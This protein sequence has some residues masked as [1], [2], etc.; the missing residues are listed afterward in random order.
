MLHRLGALAGLL[1]LSLTATALDTDATIRIDRALNSPTLTVKYTG[2][3]AALAEL[4][5]NG[6]SYGTRVLDP[7]NEKGETNF[8]LGSTVLN[9]GENQVEIRL[10]DKNGTLLG[11]QR[12][13]VFAEKTKT[14]DVFL[15]NPRSG[16][17]LQGST[18]I[19]VSVDP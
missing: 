11:T 5:L 15:S 16:Q 3:A 4:R 2:A 13:T 8:T 6:E 19:K 12:T 17:T 14:P 18:E 7:S 1:A 10:F 9:D